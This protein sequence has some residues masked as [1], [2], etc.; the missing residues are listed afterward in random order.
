MKKGQKI[1]DWQER[2]TEKERNCNEQTFSKNCTKN[3]QTI[4]E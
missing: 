2:V 3:E 4:L 1:T